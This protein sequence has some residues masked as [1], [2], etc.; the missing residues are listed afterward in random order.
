MKL[1]VPL[2]WGK[3]GLF[4]LV[5]E[6]PTTTVIFPSFLLL[7]IKFLSSPPSFLPLPPPPLS[8]SIFSILSF[9]AISAI[10]ISDY[11]VEKCFTYTEKRVVNGTV[12]NK[13]RKVKK[14]VR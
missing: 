6:R 13:H 8:L 5:K 14:L 9:I 10:G 12:V 4:A 7:N 3:R 11:M 2:S 1:H